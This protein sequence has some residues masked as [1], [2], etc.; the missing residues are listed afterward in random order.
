MRKFA[1][2]LFLAV[3]LLQLSG[4]FAMMAAGATAGVLVAHDR[5]TTG[6]IVEDQSIELKAFRVLSDMKEILEDSHISVHSYNNNVLLTGQATNENVRLAVEER[7]SDISKIRR[8]YN[9]ITIA[10]PTSL[11]TR[12]SDTWISTKLKSQMLV[13]SDVD[14]TRVHITTEDGVV[15][16]M[17]IVTPHEEESAVEVARHVRGVKKVVKMFEYLT[18]DEEI[19]G[20]LT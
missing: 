2:L 8:I 7:I 12:S 3:M 5:R 13:S 16:L 4:C 9:E 1:G 17:G 10:A 11:M 14:P 6:T 15:F 19:S 20:D 18:E